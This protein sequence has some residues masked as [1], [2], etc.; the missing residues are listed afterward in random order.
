MEVL[1]GV[2]GLVMLLGLPT[3]I[4]VTLVHEN[5]SIYYWLVGLGV[6]V[7]IGAVYADVLQR[8]KHEWKVNARMRRSLVVIS[9]WKVDGHLLEAIEGLNDL[10]KEIRKNRKAVWDSTI[11]EMREVIAQRVENGF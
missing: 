7:A 9:K 1:K 5:R 2:G 4:I 3:A 8:Y 11:S 10:L 6:I